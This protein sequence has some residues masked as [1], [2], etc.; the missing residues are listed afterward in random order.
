LFL[1]DIARIVEGLGNGGRT[2]RQAW[3]PEKHAADLLAAIIGNGIV[4]DTYKM[5]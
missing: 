5:R 2:R 1:C 4:V 3:P